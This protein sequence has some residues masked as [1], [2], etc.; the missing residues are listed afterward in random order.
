MAQN[1][2]ENCSHPDE[3]LEGYA[4]NA[5]TEGETSLVEAHVDHCPD[6][7]DTLAHLQQAT[8]LLGLSVAQ[9]APPVHLRPLVLGSLSQAGV[10]SPSTRRLP[11]TGAGRINS[12]AWALPLAAA[13]VI[14]LFGVSLIMNLRVTARVD[15]LTHENSTVTAQLGQTAAQTEQLARQNSVLSARVDRAE[16]RD[17]ELLGTMHQVQV[18]NYMSVN[19]DT[20]PLILEPP[21]GSGDSQGVLLVAD[22]GNRA[23]LMVSNMEQPPP[24][25]SY[26][27]WLVRNGQRIPVG[28]VQVDASGWGSLSLSPP[29]PVFMFDWVN[30]TMEDQAGQSASRGEMVLRSKIPTAGFPR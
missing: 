23:V 26:Y 22:K 19:P 2:S 12:S 4:L 8:A 9:Q 10:N 13:L 6:C 30:L 16:V 27:V 20:Q 29:E 1:R 14:S 28:Q 17:A 15:Q 18:A 7:R 11:I 25:R 24:F 21:S 5:L 3:L